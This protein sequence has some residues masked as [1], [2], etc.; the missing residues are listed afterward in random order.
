M[1][2]L[3]P[4]GAL[5][6]VPGYTGTAVVRDYVDDMMM[7]AEWIEPQADGMQWLRI[8]MRRMS[9]KLTEPS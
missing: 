3:P 2:D 5:V 7:I 9:A 8:D 6:H 1:S 4:I